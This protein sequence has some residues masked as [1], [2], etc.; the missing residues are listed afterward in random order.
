MLA[1]AT[2][3]LILTRSEQNRV[4]EAI[5]AGADGYILKSATPEAIVAP[6]GRPQRANR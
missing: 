6:S 5:V 3:I 1:P 2:R 4:V